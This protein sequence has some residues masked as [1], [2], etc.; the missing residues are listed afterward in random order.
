MAALK[1]V[2]H[3]I[4]SQRIS[5]QWLESNCDKSGGFLMKGQYAWFAS[6]AN[7]VLYSK[8]LG[9]IVSSRSFD[10]DQKD[11]SFKVCNIHTHI[12]IN[13]L[14]CFYFIL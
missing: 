14:I 6:G 8:Q 10:S 11:K 2:M 5:N 3:T 13:I 1:E 7:I 12:Y 9:F 4:S